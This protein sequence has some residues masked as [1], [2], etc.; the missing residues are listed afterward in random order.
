MLYFMK[1]EGDRLFWCHWQVQLKAKLWESESPDICRMWQHQ[2]HCVFMIVDTMPGMFAWR[3]I[4][5]LGTQSFN[6]IPMMEQRCRIGRKLSLLT[7]ARM[8]RIR[9]QILPHIWYES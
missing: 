2:R 1:D 4:S 3:R 8:E 5:S 7:W 9:A 6:V